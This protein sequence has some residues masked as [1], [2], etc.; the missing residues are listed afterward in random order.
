MIERPAARYGRR[1]LGH[2]QRRWITAVLALTVVAVGVLAAWVAAHRLT[3]TDVA[4][5]VVRFEV[6]DTQTVDVTFSVT[7]E[8]PSRP[9]V[10]IVRATSQD[11]SETGRR[12]VLV[13]PA[14]ERTVQVTVPVRTSKPPYVGDL[15]GCGLNVPGYLVS[16]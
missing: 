2:R 3:P 16:P 15:Y 8:D 14:A 1:H 11:G 4:G 6:V 12:E 10:C 7:R 9:A 13:P 5:K